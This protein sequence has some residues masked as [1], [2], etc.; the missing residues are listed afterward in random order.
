[1]NALR[2]TPDNTATPR[3]SSRSL[4]LSFEDEVKA[5]EAVRNRA[6]VVGALLSFAVIEIIALIN[7]PTK[8]QTERVDRLIVASMVTALL[9][10][11]AYLVFRLRRR[12]YEQLKSYSNR[13]PYKQQIV[14]STGLGTLFE[15]CDV[16]D[17]PSK[18]QFRVVPTGHER[19]VAF[20]YM[21]NFGT[22]GDIHITVNGVR[23]DEALQLIRASDL[24]VKQA[25]AMLAS[26][27]HTGQQP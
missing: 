4:V 20:V 7:T 23:L 10:A 24:T 6:I 8:N 19:N 22:P 16:P 15:P 13:L 5:R 27:G 3:S 1:M 14:D 25:M 17:T 18:M 12:S 26:Q 11:V 9:L 21:V 2:K